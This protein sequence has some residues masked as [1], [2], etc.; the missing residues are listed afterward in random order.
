MKAVF[1]VVAC[2][3][4][5][6]GCDNDS[7][8]QQVTAAPAP[9]PALNSTQRLQLIA[10]ATKGMKADRD[11]MES[12]TFYSPKGTKWADT[13]VVVYVALPDDRG[14]ILRVMPSYHGDSWIF[15]NRIK[16]MADNDIVYEKQFDSLKMKHDNNSAGVY[17][18]VDFAADDGDIG[19]LR[20]IANAKSVTVRLDGDKQQDFDMTAADRLRIQAALNAYDALRPLS[21]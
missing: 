4:T 14:P 17:E 15:F 8:P 6:A 9:K 10:D 20:K 16:V 2:A 13:G 12:I 21:Q 11:K 19:A 18:D 1:L 3:I 5:V 7:K